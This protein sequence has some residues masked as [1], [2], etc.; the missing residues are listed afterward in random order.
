M[1]VEF[2]SGGDLFERVAQLDYSFNESVCVNMIRQ[3][4][5]ALVHMHSQNIAHLDIH[6][7]NLIFVTS[8]SKRLKLIDFGKAHIL[9][10]QE[11][12][13]LAFKTPHFCTP[14][15]ITHGAV[16]KETDMWS[17]GVITYMLL[18]GTSPFQGKTQQEILTKVAGA[19]WRFE[20]N[21]WQL[22][23]TN[24]MDFIDRYVVV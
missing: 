10:P 15:V 1:I 3:V 22:I 8:Q 16:N 13:R 2:L 24:A 17:V 14:E 12:L 20:E 6:P 7:H 9:I 4:V 5:E 19:N 23:S 11:S 21:V 18:T